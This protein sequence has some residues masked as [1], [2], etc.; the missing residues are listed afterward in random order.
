MVCFQALMVLSTGSRLGHYGMTTKIG[1]GGMGEVSQASVTKL[2]RVVTLKVRP[3]AFTRDL[4]RLARFELMPVRRSA[5]QA[6]LCAS[7]PVTGGDTGAVPQVNLV[8]PLP[9]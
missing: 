6:A 7:T 1:E 9:V 3:E 5:A 8:V 4:D 2:D